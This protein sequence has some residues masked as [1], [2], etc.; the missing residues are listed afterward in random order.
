M[1][2]F[3]ICLITNDVVTLAEFYDKILNT[4]SD[5]ND[6]HTEIMIEGAFLAIYSRLDAK[7]VMELQFETGPGQ[8]TLQFGVDDVDEEYERLNKLNVEFLTKPT[9]YEWGS[10]S[11]QFKDID[12]NI[13]NFVSKA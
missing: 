5:I 8:A 9:T 6:I 12:G 10:R 13:I 1:K 11:M 2:F 3:G 4:K 7:N